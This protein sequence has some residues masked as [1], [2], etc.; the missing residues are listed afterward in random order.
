[1]GPAHAV[2]NHGLPVELVD[3][4]GLE[5]AAGDDDRRAHA[6]E[7]R[8]DNQL[9]RRG[10]GA[11]DLLRLFG[12][13]RRQ[14]RRARRNSEIQSEARTVGYGRL[15]RMA[16]GR[17]EIR[18]LDFD[19]VQTRLAGR[20]NVEAGS[21]AGVYDRHEAGELV[22]VNK[23]PAALEFAPTDALHLDG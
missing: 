5:S 17:A 21:P 2:A 6:G 22:V 19:D 11:H 20:R 8:T 14:Y 15:W 23:D 10:K 13:R 18:V 16:I 9:S 4:S 7:S 1:A 3:L 12:R